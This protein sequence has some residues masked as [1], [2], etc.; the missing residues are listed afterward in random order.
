MRTAPCDPAVSMRYSPQ[1]G[2]HLPAGPLVHP[3]STAPSL[4]D[5]LVSSSAS[6]PRSGPARPYRVEA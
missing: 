3:F 4:Y 1:A 6:S 5:G 2:V